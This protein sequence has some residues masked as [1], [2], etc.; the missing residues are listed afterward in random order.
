MIEASEAHQ[1]G[2]AEP[3]SKRQIEANETGK[4]H[5]QGSTE[6]KPK[7]R[8][9]LNNVSQIWASSRSRLIVERFKIS[10]N[11]RACALWRTWAPRYRHQ[12][13]TS[14]GQWLMMD[15]NEWINTPLDWSI[16]AC[17]ACDTKVE[18]TCCWLKILT[19]E[20]HEVDFVPGTAD[21]RHR[22]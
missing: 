2:S 16:C 4:D 14:T 21:L 9:G 19:W 6:S 1:A 10:M 17:I 3:E 18:H 8:I 13:S 20:P 22:T 12:G 15:D 11:I 7:L 5:H